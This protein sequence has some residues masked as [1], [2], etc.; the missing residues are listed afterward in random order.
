MDSLAVCRSFQEGE[1][2]GQSGK[3]DPSFGSL[4]LQLVSE[5]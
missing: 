3:L 2:E 5:A 1:K 4:E